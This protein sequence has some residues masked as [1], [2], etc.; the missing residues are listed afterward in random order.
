MG[1]AYYVDSLGS[2]P[3]VT[4]DERWAGRWSVGISSAAGKILPTHP[5]CIAFYSSYAAAPRGT[6]G[7]GRVLIGSAG[8]ASG[9]F[10]NEGGV[11]QASALRECPLFFFSGSY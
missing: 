4:E 8:L 6:E 7:S 10:K 9:G 1:L 3:Q 11:A 2:P 5:S